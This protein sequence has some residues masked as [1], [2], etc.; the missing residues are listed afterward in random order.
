MKINIKLCK[1]KLNKYSKGNLF[2]IYFKNQHKSLIKK[3]NKA[4]FKMYNTLL[5]A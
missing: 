1:L 5:N 4:N 2:G 3:N